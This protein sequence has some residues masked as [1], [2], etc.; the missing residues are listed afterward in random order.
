VCRTTQKIE[1]ILI[2]SRVFNLPGKK[3]LRQKETEKKVVVMDVT[4]SPIAGAT[5][6]NLS[7]N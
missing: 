4:E 7:W 5:H 3:E 2:C 6:L 1:N